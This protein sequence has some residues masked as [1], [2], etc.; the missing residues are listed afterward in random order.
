MS[1]IRK[2]RLSVNDIVNTWYPDRSQP[3]PLQDLCS[4][5]S[6]SLDWPYIDRILGSLAHD[7]YQFDIDYDDP[8]FEAMLIDHDQELGLVDWVSSENSTHEM[9]GNVR[10]QV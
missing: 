6:V 3:I 4:R 5:M 2:P 9:N 8:K 1:V 7:G 10:E